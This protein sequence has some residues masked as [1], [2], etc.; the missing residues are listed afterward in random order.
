MSA[1]SR[2]GVDPRGSVSERL[3]N[4]GSSVAV[5]SE[6]MFALGIVALFLLVTVPVMLHHEMWRDELQAWLLA[7]DSV[8]L[9]A[10]FHELR[11]EG[12][13][14]LWY[15]VLRVMTTVTRDPR[16][17]QW[18]S[19]GIGA[20]SVYVFARFAPFPRIIRGLFAFGY[21]VA[22]GYTI[23]ARSYGVEMLLLMVLCA[24]LASRRSSVVVGLLLILIANTSVYGGIL[25]IALVG[26]F[27]VEAVWGRRGSHS[28][29]RGVR[30]V[31]IIA[32]CG[33]FGVGLLVLQVRRPADAPFSGN[34]LGVKALLDR[35]AGQIRSRP[36]IQRLTPV[37]RAYVPIPPT[38]DLSGLWGGDA[39]LNRSPRAAPVAILLSVILLAIAVAL[40]RRSVLALVFFLLATAGTLLFSLL[41]YVGGLYH[42]G[43]F[44]LAS[45]VALWLAASQHNAGGCLA[46]E[47]TSSGRIMSLLDRHSRLLIATL[48][49]VQMVGAAFRLVGDYLFP[50]SEG[51]AVADYVRAHGF[52]GVAVAIYP[53]FQGA[54]ISGYL[55]RPVYELDRRVSAT[56]T[57]QS[58]GASRLDDAGILAGLRACCLTHETDAVLV[59]DHALQVID[60]S[61]APLEP[62]PFT[63]SMVE[64]FYLYHVHSLRRE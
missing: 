19:V 54:T 33:A 60:P 17:M 35:S 47:G 6:H 55:D 37:W 59:T 11:Y 28:I 22:Y 18:L 46:T 62:V 43:H 24:V 2:S 9:S 32:L 41:I 61:V 51:E 36:L 31:S 27:V 7:R 12:H 40:L 45:I 52:Q 29:R 16:W 53:G 13:P 25:V 5:I 64:R 39:F 44:F 4:S 20:S 56:F 58:V 34:G 57:P 42:Y 63:R 3:G 48:L 26:A 38:D 10:L 30:N 1:P 49:V 50:F 21:F 14:A 15:L 23:V 8:S